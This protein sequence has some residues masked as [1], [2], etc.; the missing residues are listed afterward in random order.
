MPRPGLL[1][2]MRA[3][4]ATGGS[5]ECTFNGYTDDPGNLTVYTFDVPTG[6]PAAGREVVVA[7]GVRALTLTTALTASVTIAGVSATIDATQNDDDNTARTLTLLARATIPT[8][9][10]ATVVVTCSRAALRLIAGSWSFSGPVVVAG[11]G[12]L[13]HFGWTG[14]ILSWSAPGHTAII[15]S[16]VGVTGVS[17]TGADI[18]DMSSIPSSESTQY[19]MSAARVTDGVTTSVAVSSSQTPQSVAVAYAPA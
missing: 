11:S 9:T 15:A 7:I 10:T 16:T 12:T 2:T 17:I 13:S 14:G 8:G 6:S 18:T 19:V 5:L 4:P 1:A 3:K